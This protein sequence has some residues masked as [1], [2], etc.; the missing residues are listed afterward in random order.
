MNVVKTAGIEASV[1]SGS[2]RAAHHAGAQ[3]PGGQSVACVTIGQPKS[4]ADV[5]AL[6]V[7][8]ERMVE[9]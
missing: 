2:R 7:Q 1:P 3:P 6:K 9:S 4:L 5:V 8:S